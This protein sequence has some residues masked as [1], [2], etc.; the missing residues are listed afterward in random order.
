[1]TKYKIIKSERVSPKILP[2]LGGI[3]K[4]YIRKANLLESTL[5]FL[6]KKIEKIDFSSLKENDR[7]IL[8]QLKEDLRKLSKLK[9]KKAIDYYW[10]CLS[11]INNY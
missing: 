1:M 8:N 10:D 2:G 3:K 7:K 9:S 11:I 6:V 5:L 4:N